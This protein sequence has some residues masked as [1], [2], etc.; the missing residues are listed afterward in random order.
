MRCLARLSV[1]LFVAFVLILCTMALA[2]Q[3]FGCQPSVSAAPAFV[4]YAAPVYTTVP[5]TVVT[6][7][8]PVYV[9]APPQ[10]VVGS[11]LVRR[12]F[13]FRWLGPKAVPVTM[14]IQVNE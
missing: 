13:P 11:A 2:A 9:T 6:Y 3:S 10:A 1:F 8:A 5:R 7:G 4:T 14:P 12:P